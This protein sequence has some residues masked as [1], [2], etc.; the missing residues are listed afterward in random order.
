MLCRLGIAPPIG[1]QY[2]RWKAKGGSFNPYGS[3][4]PFNFDDLDAALEDNDN[5]DDGCI[6][7]DQPQQQQQQQQQ[8]ETLLEE[9]AAAESAAWEEPSSECDAP[10]NL[11]D[12]S[13]T[14][15]DAAH[16][17]SDDDTDSCPDFAEWPASV[18]TLSSDDESDHDQQKAA[19]ITRSQPAAVNQAMTTAKWDA[20]AHFTAAENYD[21]PRS[22]FIYKSD[23]LGVGYYAD[24]GKLH[25]RPVA[26]AKCSKPAPTA[27]EE[28]V[29]PPTHKIAAGGA[30]SW[31]G[32]VIH[33]V[34]PSR[35]QPDATVTPPVAPHPA[36][37]SA[38]SRKRQRQQRRK[39]GAATATELPCHSSA[40]CA[41]W[42]KLGFWAID[43]F[44][45]NAWASA[46]SYLSVT[47]ADAAL[48]Q[49]TREVSKDKCKKLERGAW[50]RGWSATISLA[51]RTVAGGSSA[52]VAVLARKGIGLTAGENNVVGDAH[53]ERLHHAWMG[54]VQKG[55]VHVISIYLWTGE[56][57]T[58]RN[59]ALLH[60][61]KLLVRTLKGPWVVGGDWNIE[62]ELLQSSGWARYL[63]GQ[64]FATEGPTCGDKRYDFFL[65]SS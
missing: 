2:V 20:S 6:H 13:D 58:E 19:R 32:S 21:G 16:P 65:V 53:S 30:I 23:G 5:C 55:G 42:R 22:G 25:P 49:E 40:D 1:R 24:N 48:L 36:P 61:L 31:L 26:T 44:N 54:G 11:L 51:T 43:T 4:G 52:G 18:P 38:Q 50:A 8:W 63:K 41:D 33:K 10:P 39:A 37:R 3:E 28:L 62:P 15:E 60:R 59:L 64:V 12:C 34:L 14:E 56:G 46:E 45:P 47:S 9:A 57:L 35:T 17:A 27:L 7:E 29:M